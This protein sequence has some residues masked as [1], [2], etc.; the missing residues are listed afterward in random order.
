MIQFQLSEGVSPKD[1]ESLSILLQS[2]NVNMHQAFP[3]TYS[4]SLSRIYFVDMGAEIEDQ[5]EDQIID[6]L[7]DLSVIEFAQ[8]Q[9]QKQRWLASELS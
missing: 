8:A 2:K 3:D 5:L 6:L 9:R 7:N 1:R 4:E